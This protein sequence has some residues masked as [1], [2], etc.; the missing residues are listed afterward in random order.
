MFR[1]IAVLMIVGLLA[2]NAVSAQTTWTA[3]WAKFKPAVVQGD[4]A[5]VLSLSKSSLT[6]QDY[7]EIFAPRDIKNCFAKARPVKDKQSGYSVFCGE[8]GFY[9]EKINGQFRFSDTFAND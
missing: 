7:K 8:L 1:K 2:A 6:D 5:T 3:F 9:F 4:K